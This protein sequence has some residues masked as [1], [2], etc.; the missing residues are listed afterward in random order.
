MAGVG[1]CRRFPTRRPS[2]RDRRAAIRA[3]RSG[4]P[5]DPHR[6]DPPPL[7]GR[8]ARSAGPDRRPARGPRRRRLR[9]VPGRHRRLRD[10]PSERP[11]GRRRGRRCRRSHRVPSARC[12]R[13][14]DEGAA[15]ARGRPRLGHPHRPAGPRRSGPGD[16]VR[17]GG[18]QP[19][20]R[21]LGLEYRHRR[22]GDRR[23]PPQL[24]AATTLDRHARR[25]LPLHDPH[26]G[27][28]LGPSGR[29]HGRR[30]AARPRV[31]SSRSGRGGARLGR[32]R[33]ARGRAVAGDRS[34]VRPV[35]GGD[36]RAH[37][38]GHAAHR[39]TGRGPR[40][41][42]PR[43][44]SAH[45]SGSPWRPRRRRCRSRCCGSAASPSSPH[46]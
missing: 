35:R 7:P 40:R 29:R 33:S 44:G 28:R 24:A 13:R 15:G 36:G 38:L 32:R 14:I 4:R 6:G 26:R 34:R 45:R 8:P 39:A 17:R 22:R 21:D 3:S 11:R 37:R 30:R 18:C 23:D 10:R 9:S 31:G 2:D 16:G 5:A 41:R 43:V 42:P 25:D 1:R 19:R 20:R 46:W 27:V 12:R